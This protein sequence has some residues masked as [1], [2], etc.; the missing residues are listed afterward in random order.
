MKRN[1]TLIELLIT[2]AIIAILAS[3]LLPSLSKVRDKARSVQCQNNIKQLTMGNLSYANDNSDATVPGN[4]YGG[5]RWF[6]SSQMCSCCGHVNK[7]VKD[8]SIREWECPGC[9]ARH[10]RDRNASKNIAREGGKSYA[11][12]KGRTGQ[13]D[14][15]NYDEV[16]NYYIKLTKVRQP[17]EKLMFA[18]I[19]SGGLYDE[20]G[21]WFDKWHSLANNSTS[22]EDV[23]YLAYRH[24][25]L[26]HINVSFLD[27]HLENAHYARISADISKNYLRYHPY[28]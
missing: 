22:T 10:R 27:G 16:F 18:E 8:L 9:H 1:F 20:Y 14:V 19:V 7:E 13:H 21:S 12:N 25:G 11:L 4:V 17:S 15:D 26:R 2:I 24:G 3:L 6:A 5:R 28:E 23:G